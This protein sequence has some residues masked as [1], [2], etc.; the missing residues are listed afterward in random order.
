M[1][2]ALNRALLFSIMVY[3]PVYLVPTVGVHWISWILKSSTRSCRMFRLSRK[4]WKSVKSKQKWDKINPFVP[5][6][7]MVTETNQNQLCSRQSNQKHLVS[8]PTVIANHCSVHMMAMSSLRSGCLH[9][10][11]QELWS[12]Q[13]SNDQ[14][15]V[16]NIWILECDGNSCFFRY[17]IQFPNLCDLNGKAA[18][19]CWLAWWRQ[20]FML[21]PLRILAVPLL[22]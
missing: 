12:D 4:A 5:V 22:T 7:L 14:L 1:V 15:V 18:V 8:K 16:E 9:L 19:A 21:L 3:S 13:F 2:H 10:G 20:C 11:R 17:L 6:D